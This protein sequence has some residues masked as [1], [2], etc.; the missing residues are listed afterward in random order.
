MDTHEE[1]VVRR[2]R[3]RRA[4]RSASSTADFLYDGVYSAAIGGSVIAL[5][6]L[7]VDFIRAEPFFTPSALGHI[8]VERAPPAAGADI[9][10]DYVAIFT[11]G[12][13]I[14]FG[15]VGFSIAAMVQRLEELALHPGMVTLIVFLILEAAIL[16]PERVVMPGAVET[17]GL[18]WLTL[19]NLLTGAAMAYFLMGAHR[20]EDTDYIR[21]QK[22]EASRVAESEP[23]SI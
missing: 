14:A 20:E 6:F 1:H 7:V 16:V 9:R 18:T 4:R 2:D 3:R 23:T 21:K 13:F 11:L 12:H 8:L 10:L 5:F 17:V 19:G 22:A 15:I